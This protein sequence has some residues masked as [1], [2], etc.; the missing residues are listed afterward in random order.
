MHSLSLTPPNVY[1]LYVIGMQ[2]YSEVLN[3]FVSNVGVMWVRIMVKL[4]MA[5]TYHLTIYQDAITKDL[6]ETE[7]NPI[8]RVIYLKKTFSGLEIT[9]DSLSSGL[10]ECPFE[11][12]Q[13]IDEF[14]GFPI[15]YGELSLEELEYLSS[16]QKYLKAFNLKLYITELTKKKGLSN[17]QVLERKERN[18]KT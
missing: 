16:Q 12:S 7:F 9:S 10:I 13:W 2:E 5:K 17:K 4:I 8:F 14:I 18:L 6:Y 11:I 3:G 1:K 15:T